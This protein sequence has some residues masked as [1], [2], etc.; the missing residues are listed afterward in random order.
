M[1]LLKFPIRTKKFLITAIALVF[2][3]TVFPNKVDQTTREENEKCLNCHSKQ[4]V[5]L[6]SIS[7]GR[8]YKQ[9]MYTNCI[10]DTSLYCT[11][12]HFNF[13]CFDCYSS[14]YEIFP[15]D[16]QQRLEELPGCLD[17][18]SDDPSFEDFQSEKI[19]EEFDKSVHSSKR[20]DQPKCWSCH[21]SYYSK[22]N[23]R[24][25]MQN[26]KH[27]I[28]YDNA[29]CLSCHSNYDN[30]RLY[31]DRMNPDVTRTHDCSPNQINHF[32]D[33]RCIEC[34]TMPSDSLIV[35]HLILLKSKAV[36]KFVENHFGNSWLRASLYKLKLS[37]PGLFSD[38]NIGD[39]V[40]IG[41]PRS[42]TVDLLSNILIIYDSRPHFPFHHIDYHS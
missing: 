11:S 32:Q 3:F 14:D 15:H 4:I 10:I 28:V 27:T 35:A 16:A 37:K 36:K 33:V 7:L 22:I 40:L 30:Y 6:T 23:A 9:K 42:T 19:Q 20:S 26:L 31:V 12:N 24:D 34:H 5:I 2:S 1:M 8:S 41:S 17:C 25:R 38:R 29:I 13:K 21:N 18:H 39:A